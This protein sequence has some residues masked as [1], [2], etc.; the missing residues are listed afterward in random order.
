MGSMDVAGDPCPCCQGNE[1]VV[2]RCR[3]CNRTG[4]VQVA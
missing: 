1:A 4:V 2:D 3:R